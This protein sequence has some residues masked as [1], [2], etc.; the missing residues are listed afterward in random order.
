[1]NAK[2][3]RQNKRK[4]KNLQ[5]RV[6]KL[7][8]EAF[9]LDD[10]DIR[11]AV[12][13]E[14]GCDIKLSKYAQEVIKLSIECQ[15]CKELSIYR[16]IDQAKSNIVGNTIEAVVFKRGSKGRQTTYICLPLS[17]YLEIAKNAFD[18]GRISKHCWTTNK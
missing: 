16:T 4:G 17:M 7:F 14:H 10:H 2:Q 5:N 9:D 3:I 18:I 15:D 11:S 6:M 12:A 8:K 1:M 13:Y